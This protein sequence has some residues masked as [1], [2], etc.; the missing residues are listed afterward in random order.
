MRPVVQVQEWCDDVIATADRVYGCK[1]AK[2][3]EGPHI[4]WGADQF[5][6]WTMKWKHVPRGINR[7]GQGDR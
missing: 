5:L 3:H 2:D 7:R 1:L 6:E 4:A